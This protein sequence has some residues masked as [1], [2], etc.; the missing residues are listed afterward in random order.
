MKSEKLVFY[1]PNREYHKK[2][3]WVQE[4]ISAGFPSPA[5]DFKEFRQLYKNLEDRMRPLVYELGFLM[6]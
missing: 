3:H 1:R 6:K 5:D 4:G 2:M